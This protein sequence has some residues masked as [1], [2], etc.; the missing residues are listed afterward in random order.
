MDF[1]VRV[2][3][4]N[5]IA[6]A[7]LDEEKPFRSKDVIVD[8]SDPSLRLLLKGVT[9][10]CWHS[11]FA[12]VEQDVRK[13]EFALEWIAVLKSFVAL[14]TVK[15]LNQVAP[16]CIPLRVLRA[17]VVPFAFLPVNRRT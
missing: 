11:P 6:L 14:V 13:S 5:A 4:G 17:S 8:L 12:R 2:F 16:L 10:H 7:S 1:P 15:Y 9:L 3:S